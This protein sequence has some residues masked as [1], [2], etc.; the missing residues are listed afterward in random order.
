MH[1]ILHIK[2][3][4]TDNPEHKGK[5]YPAGSYFTLESKKQVQKNGLYFLQTV[6]FFIYNYLI[7]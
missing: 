4:K 5:N 2:K 1:G 6:H 3:L 7:F